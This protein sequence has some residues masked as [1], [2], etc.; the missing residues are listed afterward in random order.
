MAMTYFED[1]SKYEYHRGVDYREGTKNIGWLA[2]GHAFRIEEPTDAVLEGLWQFCKV[3]IAQ[4]RGW[5]QC[6]FCSED[7]FSAERNGEKLALGTSEIR[8]FS[9][10]DTIYAA[11]TLIYHYV[12]RHHYKPPDEFLR[13]ML[14]G[15]APNTKE[16][17]DILHNLGLE[18]RWT[19]A[20]QGKIF[21][22][23][24]SR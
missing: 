13:A 12:E 1:L 18:W 17:F 6:E 4:T 11:P 22:I 19:S 16:Y 2:A 9:K 24:D 7:S 5:H 21:R 14:D 10:N 8:V 3:S 23:S 20:P 15:P